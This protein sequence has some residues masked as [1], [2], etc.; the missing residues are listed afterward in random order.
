M[1]HRRTWIIWKSERLLRK[2]HSS[3]I[4]L[5]GGDKTTLAKVY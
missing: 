5:V 2:L 3:L 1:Y 4:D